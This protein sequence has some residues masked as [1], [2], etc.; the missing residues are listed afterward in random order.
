[1]LNSCPIPLKDEDG[2]VSKESWSRGC[3]TLND[4][5]PEEERIDAGELFDVLDLDG[6]D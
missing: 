4:A 6:E 1:M 5:L 3:Q 2:K